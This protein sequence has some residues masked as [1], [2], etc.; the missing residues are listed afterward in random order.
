VAAEVAME[1]PLSMAD[2]DLQSAREAVIAA[3]RPL[4]PDEVVL[5]Q[6]RTYNQTEG[7]APDSTTDTYV[8]ARLWIDTDR[9][10]GVPFVLRTGKKMAVSAQRVSLIFKPAEGPLHSAGR[11]PNVLAFDLKGNGAIEIDMTVKK[12][13]P[14]PE[15]AESTT[16]LNLENVAEGGMTAYTSLIY[17]VFTGNRSLFTSSAGLAAAFRAFQPLL[18]QPPAVQ[19]YEDDSW[20]PAAADQLTDGLGWQLS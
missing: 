14:E 8:A 4:D 6:F 10:L 18:D 15:P 1:P 12:P 3:F 20:G 5:G 16:R 2:E 17:D 7:I 13:G 9:W 11:F 19:T